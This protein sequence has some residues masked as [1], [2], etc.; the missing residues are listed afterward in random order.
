[1]RR[2]EEG[3]Y[4]AET[5]FVLV[6]DALAF[7]SRLKEKKHVSMNGFLAKPASLHSPGVV[8][9]AGATGRTQSSRYT[10][11]ERRWGGRASWRTNSVSLETSRAGYKVWVRSNRRPSCSRVAHTGMSLCQEFKVAVAF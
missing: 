8:S 7:R 2:D 10:D 9:V 6:D 4:S 1:M 5:M 11:P 3:A